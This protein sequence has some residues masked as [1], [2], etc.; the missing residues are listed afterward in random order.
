MSASRPPQT[1]PALSPAELELKSMWQDAELE[2]SQLTRP[3]RS[4]RTDREK[5]LEDVLAELDRKYRPPEDGDKASAAKARAKIRTTIGQVL[6]CIQLLGG[7]AAQGASI[8]FG[9]ATLCFNAISFLIDI[10][11]RV[12]SVYEGVGNLFEEISHFL[13]LF[14][15]Y[16]N[17]TTLDPS[18]RDG[19]HK[20]M[21]SLVRI[22]G[23]SIRII[24]GGVLHHIKIGAKITFLNDDS[25]VRAE[26]TKFKAL[27]DKQ[28][29][30]TEA[31]TLQHVLSSEGKIVEV[32][33]AHYENAEK[34]TNLEGNM[35]IVVADVN[36]RKMQMIVS[37]RVEQIAKMLSMTKEPAEDARRSMQKMRDNLLAG[38]G[39]W[40]LDHED[41][42]EWKTTKS[43]AIP[44]LLL[45][46]DAK[47]GKSS[48]LAAI[49]GNIRKN[50][51]DVA[52]AYYEFVGRD[53]KILRDKN[54]VLV[55]ALKSMALQIAGQYK[56][57]AR[58]MAAQRDD[59]KPPEAGKE[60]DSVE[61][62]WWD[63]LHFSRFSRIKEDANVILIFDG[64]EELSDSNRTGFLKFLKTITARSSAKAVQQHVRIIATGAPKVFENTLL[65]PI[66]I[67]ESN[68][69]DIKLYI[70]EELKTTES[71]QGQHVEMLD[72]LEAIQETLPEVARGSFSTVQQ[73]LE[74]IKEAVDS[75]AYLDDVET[76]L[77]EDPA[78][79]SGKLAWKILSDLNATLNAHEIDQLNKLLHWCVFGF[80]PF[81]IDELRAT[82]YL[83]SGKS[84]LQPFETKLR[85]KYA[86]L[87]TIEGDRVYM[88]D[89]IDELFRF[90]HPISKNDAKADLENARISMTVSINQ[91]D[92]RSVQQ[93][94]WDLTER[95]G[96]GRFDFLNESNLDRDG[97]GVIHTEMGQAHLHITEQLLKLLND[98]LNEKTNCLVR[99]ALRQLPWHLREL[100]LSLKDG[101]LEDEQRRNIG[102]GVVDL[103]SDAEGIGKFLDAKCRLP[104]DWLEPDEAVIFRDWLTDKRVID[105]LQPKERRWVKL[106][107]ADSEGNSGIFKPTTLAVARRWLRDRDWPAWKTY[108]WIQ[109][110]IG[111]VN[112]D[113]ILKGPSTDLLAAKYEA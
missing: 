42:E 29:H 15:I 110:Y 76:I 98:E 96:I 86:K 81:D 83:S 43:D 54:E 107:T 78:E 59:F 16:E 82:V 72:L 84:T 103:L 73:K 19:T 69:A 25:G 33:N 104:S 65:A 53:A 17:Y 39:Q 77:R 24:E 45:S 94:F 99:Y 26:L 46:G 106:H 100:H 12:A 80:G 75:D 14:K 20:L 1:A 67:S 74:R 30:V 92:S 49:E 88:E 93:F 109:S 31:V 50:N 66:A 23:L 4:L 102:K 70:E 40:L 32:L 90:G 5:R 18:L 36:D 48:L 8:V 113:H 91:A 60:K 44:L 38:S 13:V 37:E 34:L 7:L 9:P 51:N 111:L 62:L 108:V 6:S 85:K 27:I 22:C 3:S 61:K 101:K 55:L 58:E 56:L 35:S 68:M 2:F 47:T 52:V 79:D 57:Y 64:L 11:G 112:F 21:V 41:Y 87:F 63:K 89:D 105:V 71:L 28:S 10:P 95:V 97:K